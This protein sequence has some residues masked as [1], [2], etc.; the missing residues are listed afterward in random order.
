MNVREEHEHQTMTT[1]TAPT[2]SVV[3]PFA[4]SRETA[5][6]MLENLAPLRL[7]PFAEGIISDNSRDHIVADLPLP[8]GW[9]T[10]H[11][12][13][14][15]SPARA[16]NAGA[17]AATGE[18]L[19]FVDSDCRPA[20]DLL[21]AYFGETIGDRTGLVAGEVIGARDQT[22]L[23]A[24]YARDRNF[25]DQ[26]YPLAHDFLPY[27]L[28]ANLLVRRRVWRELGGF[29]EG[30]L[31]AEDVDFAWRAQEAGWEVAFN[32]R[33]VLEHEH[34]EDIKGLW[35]Q[36]RIASASAVWVHRRWP[37]APIPPNPWA[38]ALARAA[39]GV[40]GH[41]IA[42][43]PTRAAFKALDGLIALG[44]LAGRITDN[45]AGQWIEAAPPARRP[46]QVWCDQFPV[47]SET[48]VI[49][50]VRELAA[51]GH[52]VTVVAHRR[53]ARPALGVHD[54]PVRYLEDD[55]RVE[56]AAALART[57]FRHPLRSARDRLDRRR[58]S[59]EEPVPRLASLGPALRALK[60]QDP[61]V[62]VHFAGEI[63]LAALR[64]C[65]IAKR[66]W[67]LTAHAYDIYLL[68]RN[69]REKLRSAS[70]VTSGCEYTVR[71]L[72]EI[73]GPDRAA[74]VHEIVMGVNAEQFRR[75]TPYP[76]GATV[77]AIGRLVEKKGFI[78]LIRAAADPRLRASLDEIVIVGDGPLKRE[79]EVEAERLGVQ[80]VVRLAGALE[81]DEV[82][83]T[84]EQAA[85]LAVPCVVA[86]DGDRDS[87][88]VVAKEALAMEIPVVATDE[89]GL[90]ELIRPEFGRL[91]PPGEADALAAAL[92]ELLE[93][94]R[95]ERVAMGHAGRDWVCRHANVKFE[96]EKL[97]G[98]FD[99][100]SS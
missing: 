97:S 1:D 87:M 47:L 88:P 24:R 62:H 76:T 94:D 52:P 41:L 55:T 26:R 49:N 31:N 39:V 6:H 56:Q 89:V 79:L 95:A 61:H 72:R 30:I 35:K 75:R 28:T 22:A 59:R 54:V 84:L 42:G 58:W 73:A 92:T 99:E 67:S 82:R 96:T 5:I 13:G 33:A 40:P 18:W 10:V 38:Q 21:E 80:D 34:R 68:P 100:V 29:L 65:R 57:A 48:F 50:E 44:T 2:A 66:P 3:V 25:L 83:E 43:R 63:A 4:G 27:A 46:V 12:R 74:N 36:A 71:D 93:L 98:L 20:P 70:L 51:L 90:P 60:T 37:E 45:R 15:G 9:R 53:P 16:R 11:A 69:L 7:G 32:P 81:P 8:T 64:A 23:A 19:L 86:G 17:L 78:H 77:V 85:L 14:E 91:V